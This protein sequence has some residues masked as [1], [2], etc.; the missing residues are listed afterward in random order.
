MNNKNRFTIIFIL[1]IVLVIFGSFFAVWQILSTQPVISSEN[2]DPGP[3]KPVA[4][5]A[6][7]S[8]EYV[9]G[10]QAFYDHRFKLAVILPTVEE[11]TILWR[12]SE[13]RP[14][15]GWHK[16]G[17]DD[18]DWIEKPAAFGNSETT[19][20]NSSW[21][22]SEIWLRKKFVL[23]KLPESLYLKL[24]YDDEITV[25]I[26]GFVAYWN[27]DFKNFYISAEASHD[28]FKSL[29]IGENLITVKCRQGNGP[30][31]VDVGLGFKVD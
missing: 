6:A 2:I 7:G 27:K 31:S 16:A 26:N 13:S 24:I 14:E 8:T 3:A 25:W 29:Q 20:I 28:A 30:Q 1:L 11:S 17:F 15:D 10:I 19:R 5:E 23:K 12:V 18:S 4:Y 22:S 21:K 9:E